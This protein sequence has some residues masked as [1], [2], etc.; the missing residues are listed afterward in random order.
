LADEV[1]IEVDD[2]GPGISTED[3]ERVFDR[4]VRL[5]NSRDRSSGTAGLGLAIEREIALA[6][7]GGIVILGG[8]ADGT[9]VVVSLPCTAAAVAPAG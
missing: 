8:H 3:R 6:H 9:R 2:D 1:R 5:D 4:F 7:C